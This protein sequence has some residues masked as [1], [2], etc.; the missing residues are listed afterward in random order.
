MR[1]V[2]TH[3]DQDTSDRKGKE[4]ATA[5]IARPSP[6]SPQLPAFDLLVSCSLQLADVT[7]YAGVQALGPPWILPV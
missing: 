5:A 7:P 6:V 3:L 2:K 4:A 1:K